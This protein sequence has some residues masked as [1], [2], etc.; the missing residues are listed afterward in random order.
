M[1]WVLRAYLTRWDTRAR[2]REHRGRQHDDDSQRQGEMDQREV[3]IHRQDGKPETPAG[4]PGPEA[5]VDELVEVPEASAEQ[6]VRDAVAPGQREEVEQVGIG[7]EHDECRGAE[8][9]RGEAVAQASG[10]V[11]EQAVGGERRKPEGELAEA[12]HAGRGVGQP[13]VEVV[14][15][16]RHRPQVRRPQDPLAGELE[17][18]VRLVPGDR[19]HRGTNGHVPEEQARQRHQADGGAAGVAYRGRCHQ[20]AGGGR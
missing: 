12:E 3:R 15:V 8:R 14:I 17:V 2:G 7:V 19:H 11:E 1:A 10:G 18:V 16:R 13:R 9:Q 20:L 6:S 4:V 5:R